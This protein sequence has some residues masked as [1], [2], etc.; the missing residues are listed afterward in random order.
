MKIL[1]QHHIVDIQ[2]ESNELLSKSNLKL[3]RR[4]EFL[5]LLENAHLLL[6]NLE[7]NL[8]APVI[9]WYIIKIVA[10][11]NGPTPGTKNVV[12]KYK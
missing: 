6:T 3:K 11:E 9:S 8:L 2:K 7:T 4:K 5:T 12:F 10:F 1:K